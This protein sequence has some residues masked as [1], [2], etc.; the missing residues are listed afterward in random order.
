MIR[1]MMVAALLAMP[2]IAAARDVAEL[3]CLREHATVAD[4]KLL[5]DAIAS[6]DM[7]KV[8]A[9]S[10]M[11]WIKADPCR[12]RYRWSGDVSEFAGGYFGALL[13]RNYLRGVLAGKDAIL[14]KLDGLIA[15]MPADRRTRLGGNARTKDDSAWLGEQ[16]LGMGVRPDDPDFA[17]VAVY[18]ISS[19]R[20]AADTEQWKTL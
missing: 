13:T 7:E 6:K 11:V 17:D 16:L 12:L 15:G 5:F 10:S 2:G 4:G 9:A 3:Q 14:A 8:S 20:V 1:S 18:V 19:T